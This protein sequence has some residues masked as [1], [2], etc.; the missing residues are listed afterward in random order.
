MTHLGS[1]VAELRRQKNMTQQQLADRLRISR[2][3]LSRIE[4]GNSKPSYDVLEDLLRILGP[5]V[6]GGDRKKSLTTEVA[7]GQSGRFTLSSVD[8]LDFQA[9]VVEVKLSAEIA[10]GEPMHYVSDG[11]NVLI[12]ED[13][14]PRHENEKL[15]RVRGD[16]MVEHGLEDGDYL[17]VEMR[18]GGVAATGDLVVAW[19]NGGC[20]VKRWVRKGGRKI[21]QAGNPERE[22]FELTPDDDFRLIGIVRRRVRFE[23]FPPPPI[24]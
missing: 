6:M 10:A 23:E 8:V 14:A 11:E 4:T 15:V 24:H 9:G 2:V 21:L 22:S 16:S 7:S 13:R 1:R 17:I 20:T 3:H 18:E 12:P 5:D 19:Y